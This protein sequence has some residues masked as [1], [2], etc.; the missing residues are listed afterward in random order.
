MVINFVRAGL[1]YEASMQPTKAPNKKKHSQ[2]LINGNIYVLMG[3]SIKPQ[4]VANK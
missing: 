4:I 2:I 1:W 3:V